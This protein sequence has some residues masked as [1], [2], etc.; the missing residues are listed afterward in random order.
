[1]DWKAAGEWFGD[2]AGGLAAAVSPAA[3]AASAVYDRVSAPAVASG[4]L[5]QLV[6]TE[7]DQVEAVARRALGARY[8]WSAGSVLS[9]VQS[10]QVYDCSSFALACARST[11]HWSLVRPE[12]TVR[13]LYAATSPVKLGEQR[14][15]DFAFYRNNSGT[16]AHVRFNV[17]K[18]GLNGHSRGYG[19]DSGGAATKGDDPK[20]CVKVADS[21]YWPTAGNTGFAGFR[22]SPADFDA[23]FAAVLLALASDILAGRP[24]PVDGVAEVLTPFFRKMYPD[25]V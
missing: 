22:R 25:G 5:R 4:E 19:C 11:G 14:P 12:R 23:Y 2:V 1:M 18:P 6:Y 24:L 15:G 20:A 7:P 9:P 3:A 21:D 16:I 10:S 13:D 17:G 8:Y